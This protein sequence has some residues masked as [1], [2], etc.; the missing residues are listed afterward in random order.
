MDYVKHYPDKEFQMDW[1]ETY[2][3]HWNLANNFAPPTSKDVERIYVQVNKFAAVSEQSLAEKNV[4]LVK[5]GTVIKN[6]VLHPWPQLGFR[7]GRGRGV[8]R[9]NFGISY[10][11]NVKIF[12][13]K[14]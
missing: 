5:R 4:P 2:L 3:H 8:M 9:E 6:T 14:S 12:E 1:L 10:F 13:C 7:F 11:Q